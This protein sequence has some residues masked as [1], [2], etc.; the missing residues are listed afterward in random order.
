MNKN[1]KYTM[2]E[3]FG[4]EE[5]SQAHRDAVDFSQNC[6]L[7]E[8][9]EEVPEAEETETFSGNGFNS[10]TVRRSVSRFT[11]DDGSIVVGIYRTVINSH[12]S[13]PDGW[14]DSSSMAYYLLPGH[15]DRKYW[16]ELKKEYASLLV[17]R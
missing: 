5:T 3:L 7:V 10:R 8:T 15:P 4:E 9:L 1:T 13:S 14:S 12:S 2:F 16:E 11:N 17:S 6:H